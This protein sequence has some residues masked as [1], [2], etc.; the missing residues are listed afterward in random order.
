M[1]VQL[2][3]FKMASQN[4]LL[5]YIFSHWI[6]L[7]HLYILKYTHT[8]T[9]SVVIIHL[10]SGV[11]LFAAPQT[12]AHQAPLSSSISPSL[13]KS[14][15]IESVMLSNHVILCCSLLFLPSV[16]PSILNTCV[17]LGYFWTNVSMTYL[18]I[19]TL[20]N[21]SNLWFAFSSSTLVSFHCSSF[22]EYMGN[23]IFILSDKLLYPNLL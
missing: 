10:L 15:V 14:M 19:M 4:F 7:L 12:V 9:K 23:H 2:T 5:N 8:H 13:L 6:E 21:C 16:F 17:Y 11:W 20:L 3:F 18:S 22:L 1:N